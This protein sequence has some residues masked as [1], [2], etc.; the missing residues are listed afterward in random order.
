MQYFLRLSCSWTNWPSC[1]DD[2]TAKP[3]TSPMEHVPSFAG[4]RRGKADDDRKLGQHFD[5]ALGGITTV[6]RVGRR[7]SR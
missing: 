5:E 7:F 1:F 6:R 3:P 4:I 2:L